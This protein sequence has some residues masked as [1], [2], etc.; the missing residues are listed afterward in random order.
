MSQPPKYQTEK[1]HKYT[2]KYFGQNSHSISPDRFVRYRVLGNSVCWG[3]RGADF[4]QLKYCTHVICLCKGV[5]FLVDSLVPVEW[6]QWHSSREKVLQKAANRLA[7]SPASGFWCLCSCWNSGLNVDG[8]GSLC[9][10]SLYFPNANSSSESIIP[11]KFKWIFSY[12]IYIIFL[13]FIVSS[14]CKSQ[15]FTT[16]YNFVIMELFKLSHIIIY[17]LSLPDSTWHL[18]TSKKWTLYFRIH[19][20]TWV[21]EN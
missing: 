19:Y 13:V 20:F 1:G 9:S 7:L 8:S 18:Q 11:Q 4:H 12:I 2:P 15:F 21:S 6:P 3:E 17:F 14:L 10:D 5:S 16:T